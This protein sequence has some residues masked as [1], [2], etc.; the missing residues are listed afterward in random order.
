[1][2]S[3]RS[4]LQAI[5]AAAAVTGAAVAPKAGKKAPS[6][7][8]DTKDAARVDLDTCY[9]LGLNGLLELAKLDKRLEAF[10]QSL[11]SRASMDL[12]RELQ[13]QDFNVALDKNINAL[14]QAL[15]PHF[16][17][18]PCQKVL[19]YLV[20]RYRIHEHNVDQLIELSMPYHE[21]PL[22]P[23]MLQL[24][25]VKYVMVSQDVLC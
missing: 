15:G 18:R 12:V 24:I 5:S 11:F 7:L 16:L 3:L 9:N 14:L 10:E 20:R 6:V 1:M 19:E 25:P 21:T 22:F 2:S 23:R 17:Q 13:P 4:Q 8:F